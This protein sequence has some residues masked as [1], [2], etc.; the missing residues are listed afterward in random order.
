MMATQDRR[1]QDRARRRND[2]L[3]SARAVFAQQGFRRATVDEIAQRAEV[4][5]G[6]I[7]LYFENK[8]AILADLVLLAL[9]DLRSQLTSAIEAHSI[10]QPDGQLRAMADAYLLFSQ[11]SPDFYRLLTA[12]DGGDLGNDL[13]PQRNQLILDA[14]SYTLDLVAQV[15]A[16]GMALGMF[17][18]RDARQAAAVLWAG[19]NGSLALLSHPIRRSMVATDLPGLYHATLELLL[20]GLTCAEGAPPSGQPTGASNESEKEMMG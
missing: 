7:Y 11:R 5:K 20:K 8:E 6:T 4:A 19:L 1:E 17:A 9:A 12:F 14:S 18:A 2:I 15:I 13:S 3:L 10:L 16:D